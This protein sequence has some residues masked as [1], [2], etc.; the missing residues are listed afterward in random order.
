MNPN[1]FKSAE[2]YQRRYHNFA[3][4]LIVP[5]VLLTVFILLFSLIAQ[6][7]I[8][9]TARGEIA[10]TRVIAAIQSTSN[11]PILTNK[12]SQNLIVQKGDLLLTYS[13]TMESSQKASLADQL[14]KLK[15]QKTELD[16][17]KASL[18]QGVNLFTTTDEFGYSNTFQ[19]FLNQ[20]QDIELG[21]SKLNTEVTNQAALANSTAATIDG[22]IDS[23]YQQIANYEE[24][25]NAISN[26]ESNL[27]PGNP[28]QVTLDSYLAQV[29]SQ[30]TH[31]DFLVG[32]DTTAQ[33][34]N[35][36]LS[37]INQSISSL[38]NSINNLNIQRAG[39]G[40]VATYDNSLETKVEVLR[41]QFLQNT[42]QQ[43]TALDKELA[44]VTTQLDLAN[45]RLDQ[46]SITAP[47]SGV[48]QVNPE[49]SGKNLVPLGTDMAYIYPE[50]TSKEEVLINYYVT[51]DYIS[52]LKEGQTVRL[53][54]EKVGKEALTIVGQVDTIDQTATKTEQGNLFQIK[55]KAQIPEKDLA[56]V[57]Y[58]L[59]GRVTSVITTKS[60]FD[61]YKDKI[62]NNLE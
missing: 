14:A 50:L 30:T 61:Y 2:F 40:S 24:L 36:Y 43:M 13:E 22:Q 4:L 46:T 62:L 25:F 57:Q 47:E 58:G 52:L 12:L 32:S 1:L 60:F 3:T 21:I 41:T 11:N 42:A 16:T 27:S 6:K 35:Q 7:E 56:K 38:E 28:H 48:I 20:A 59:E 19:N 44:E 45:V 17:L 18:E 33:I 26:Q 51:S 54:L 55:A 15:R 10:P 53:K 34:T 29:Q 8:T 5:L 23:L 31:D 39:T 37:Q 49:I 9:I